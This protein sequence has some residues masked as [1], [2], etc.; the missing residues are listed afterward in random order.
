LEAESI[1]SPIEDDDEFSA[2]AAEDELGDELGDEDNDDNEERERRLT[3]IILILIMS[4]SEM[5][6]SQNNTFQRVKMGRLTTKQ[7]E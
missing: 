1:D 2:D 5:G 4:K 7:R 3:L 6:L